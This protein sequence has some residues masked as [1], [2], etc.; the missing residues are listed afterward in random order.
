MLQAIKT[1]GN[2]L[3]SGESGDYPQVVFDAIKDNQSYIDL[4][5]AHDAQRERPWFLLFFWDYFR[6]VWDM[7]IFDDIFA[8]FAA[9][10]C[11]DLQHE[12]FKG[13]R[14]FVTMAALQVD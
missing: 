5:L 14:P 6:V 13:K 10:T 11:S 1:L 2:K 3:W 9:F 4:I 8:K 12:R 7:P